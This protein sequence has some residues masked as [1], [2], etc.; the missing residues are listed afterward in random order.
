VSHSQ[1]FAKSS[2]DSFPFAFIRVIGGLNFGCGGAALGTRK[3][4]M[5]IWE[6]F[7]KSKSRNNQI[8]RDQ[9]QL[10]KERRFPNRR[11]FLRRL[12]NRR[13]LEAGRDELF[14]AAGD[15]QFLR[16]GTQRWK[17]E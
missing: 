13:S 1:S 4:R 9:R 6:W 17:R 11:T 10:V 7:A 16:G 15:D 2:R 5:L 8:A 3:S 12:G 14:G